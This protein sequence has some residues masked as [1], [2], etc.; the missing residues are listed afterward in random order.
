M[1]LFSL[2]AFSLLCCL[3]LLTAETTASDSNL[4]KSLLDAVLQRLAVLEARD[5]ESQER[6]QLLESE[7]AKLKAATVKC[8]EET[9]S[10]DLDQEQHAIDNEHVQFGDSGNIKRGE[11]FS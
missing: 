6:I 1:S 9:S 8:Q 4:E 5:D 2:V 11:Y 7:V 10:L 3:A